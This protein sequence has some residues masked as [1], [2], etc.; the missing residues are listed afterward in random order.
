MIKE[1][2]YHKIFTVSRLYKFYDPSGEIAELA[3][4][5]ASII[6]IQRRFK[7]SLKEYREIG[8]NVFL[9][10]GI[11]FLWNCLVYGSCSPPFGS[12]AQ[13]CV[14]NGTTPVSSSQTGLT[15]SQTFCQTQDPGYPVV[16]QNQ[17][18]FEATY[19]PN[20]ANFCWNEWGVSNGQVFLNR[21]QVSL[22]T[23]SYPY[24]W[25]FQVI[26]TIQ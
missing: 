17:V 18:T 2:E 21:A 7:G 6:E 25:V 26:L 23:K 16:S 20:Q 4:K 13:I 10:A 5:G 11:N 15:G 12:Q 1:E 9:I 24:T 3:R 22:G 14:G 19:N 8:G